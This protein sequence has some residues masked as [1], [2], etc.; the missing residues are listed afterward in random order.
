MSITRINEFQSAPGKEEELF[1][2]LNSILPYIASSEG[3]ISCEVL[4]HAEN[5]SSFVVIEKW[6]SIE[7][8]KQSVSQFPKEKMQAAM[9]LFGLPPKG[10]YYA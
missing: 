10:A 3:A 2:F 4:R 8:H 1:L 7:A 9:S 5:K 6:Q